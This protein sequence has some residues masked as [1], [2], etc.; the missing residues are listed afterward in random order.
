MNEYLLKLYNLPDNKASWSDETQRA[1]LTACET[2][3][4]E[5]QEAHALIAAQPLVRTGG[6]IV[7]RHG[8][9]FTETPLVGSPDIQVG[10]YHIRARSLSDAIEIAK[11]NPE[12]VYSETARIEVRL[13]RTH[14]VDT[15]FEYPR[16]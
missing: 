11:R 15:G 12:L 8:E 2:H 10:Y 9:G 7:A 4:R 3:I 6:V 14:E 1:F 5:L 13:L 16:G